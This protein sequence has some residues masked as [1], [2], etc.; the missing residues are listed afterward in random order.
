MRYGSVGVLAV[1]A[2]SASLLAAGGPEP[3]AQQR[4]S[5]QAPAFRSGIEAVRVDVGVVDKQGRPLRGLTPADFM[6]TVGGQPRRVVTAEFIDQGAARAGA[7][8]EPEAEFVSTNEGAGVGRLFA[9]IV[10]QS[11]LDPTGARRVSAA[12]GTFL[13]RLSFADRSAVMVIPTGPSVAFTWA[14]DRVRSALQ[15]VA[16]TG[17]PVTGWEAGSLAEARDIA[18]RDSFAL[19]TVGE[20]VCGAAAAQEGAATASAV[21]VPAPQGGS[22]SPAGGTGGT[23]GTTPAA[24][25][26]GGR[27]GSPRATGGPGGFATTGCMR[28][29]QAQADM[30]W[31]TTQMNSLSS[32]AALRVA[33]NDLGRIPGDKTAV[34]ISG[35]W[36][37]DQRDEISLLLTVA[38]EAAAARVTLF[39][40]FVPMPLVSTDRRMMSFS[41]IGDSN[42]HSGPL[43]NLAAMTGGGSYRAEAGAEAVFERIS[44]ELAGFYRLGIEGDPADRNEKSQRLKVQVLRSGARARAREIFDVRTY[45]DRD[46]TA[47]LASAVDGPVASTDLGLRV[48]SFL[49]VDSDDRSRLRL[50]VSGEVSRARP[51]EANLKL[52]V[53]DVEGRKVAAGDT[54]V[55]LTGAD[56]S[57]FSANIAVPRGRYIVRVGLMDSA[58]RVGSADHIVEARG[59]PLGTL[60][61]AGPVLVRVANDGAGEP[62]FAVDHVGRDERLA[63]EVGLEG[64]RERLENTDVE[65]EIAAA[66][67][68]PALLRVP[69]ALSKGSREDSG[70]AQAVASM[71]V[72]PPG[73]YVVRARV[74]SGGDPI[75]ELRRRF[76]VV[77]A[78]RAADDTGS[79]PPAVNHTDVRTWPAARLPFVASPPFALDQV[80]SPPVLNVFLDR[81][82]ARPDAA[83]PAVRELVERAR[84]GGPRGF[85]VS[86]S[87]ATGAPVAAFVKGLT[88]LSQQK[89]D[90]AAA[91]FREAMRASADFSPA[92]VYL[93]A[94]YAAG[95]N[96]KEAAAIWRTALIREGDAV[97][98]HALLADALLRQGRADLAVDDLDAARARWPEDQGL[99]RRFVMAALLAG[100]QV[101][102]LQVLDEAVARQ[103]DDEPS[104]ALAL[105]M[106]YQA[107]ETGEP[108]ESASQDRERMRR[109]ANRYRETGGP[110]LALVDTWVAAVARQK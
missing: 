82:A 44:G 69:A 101:E 73:P 91:A 106:L 27:S 40:V 94:C 65:F 64:D 36:P 99:T 96:D 31:R 98:L 23:T 60:S 66:A 26:A 18:N 97:S 61:A 5:D 76:E 12:A 34:L 54:P 10:D 100:R 35:G 86:E 11:S 20:R 74:R 19:R 8:A 14:H 53:S 6:V 78:E 39:T 56:A 22:A 3:L 41:P 63:F 89:L 49:A 4:G 70:F 13:S 93:G 48:T 104:L 88:L 102:G 37:M 47:R 9:F 108:I 42:L 25:A 50:L 83:S 46:W 15:R 57:S 16:G 2:A 71:R 79:R 58:G 87:Q 75:G 95:G 77:G 51:G 72:L 92:M 62:R 90:P 55:V 43:E 80:L 32:L 68:G 81:V 110:S 7:P 85:V 30:A 45:A 52:L 67:D 28:E 21:G 107:F 84:A 105:F 1:A 59:V 33:I 109:L 29:V 38:A 24:P 17:R 103:V